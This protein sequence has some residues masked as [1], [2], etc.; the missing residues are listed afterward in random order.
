MKSTRKPGIGVALAAAVPLLY[1]ALAAVAGQ[2][3]AAPAGTP[4]PQAASSGAPNEAH[5]A[6]VPEG[7]VANIHKAVESRFK[8]THVLDVRSSA[9]AGVYE[10]F[11]GDRIVYSD[12]TGD[13]L[14]LGDLVDTRTHVNLT[15]AAMEQLSAIDFKS[16]PFDKA[17]KIVK[18]N[19]SRQLAVFE[20]PDCPY[21]QRL[22]GELKS[23]TNL[24]EYV[25]LFPIDELHS[26]ASIHA[27][28][29]WCASDRAKAWTDYLL[30]RKLPPETKCT[31]DPV[32]EL[33][34]LGEKRNINGTPTAYTMDGKRIDGAVSAGDLEKA[35]VASAAK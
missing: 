30:T 9:I 27:H 17:I 5:P 21:C 7:V 6:P 25:F 33:G 12:A 11:V 29:I 23:V 35:L 4:A 26:K 32:P 34:K 19:G 16:L 13:Y 20:D 10:V 3:V 22:E 18:G 24:T 31:G 14:I 1:F 2:G 8:G 28:A 15:H